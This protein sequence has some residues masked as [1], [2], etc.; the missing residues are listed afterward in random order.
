MSEPK[1]LWLENYVPDPNKTFNGSASP[2]RIAPAAASTNHHELFAPA[3]YDLVDH[4]PSGVE[5][6][7]ETGLATPMVELSAEPILSPPSSPPVGPPPAPFWSQ[8][9]YTRPAR[10]SGHRA[11]ATNTTLSPSKRNSLDL[12]YCEL[13]RVSGYSLELFPLLE[14]PTNYTPDTY[15]LTQDV[16][17]RCYWLT[18]LEVSEVRLSM[19]SG[20]WFVLVYGRC[21][22][23]AYCHIFI[24]CVYNG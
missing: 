21:I 19:Q 5:P 22:L 13:D 3:T 1:T 9:R 11:A 8:L 10:G 12:N 16:D 2:N 23:Y 24:D 6:V 14:S 20:C 7:I 18:C 17:A 4:E 15:D